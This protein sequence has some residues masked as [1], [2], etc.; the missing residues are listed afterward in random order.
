[1]TWQAWAQAATLLAL[2]GID[3]CREQPWTVYALSLLAFGAVS[4]PRYRFE[5]G[6]PS[7]D[8]SR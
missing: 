4:V 5:P 6:T 8:G 3:R 1:M 7:G 2:G